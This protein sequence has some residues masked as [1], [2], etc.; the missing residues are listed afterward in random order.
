MK[1]QVFLKVGKYEDFLRIGIFLY[2]DD[3][4]LTETEKHL[5]SKYGTLLVK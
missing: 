5:Q 2:V 1:Q 4:V 3:L